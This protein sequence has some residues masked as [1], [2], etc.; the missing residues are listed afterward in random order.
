MPLSNEQ[1]QQFSDN[2]RT[3]KIICGALMGG[4]VMFALVLCTIIDIPNLNMD[5]PLLVVMAAAFGMVM[6]MMSF[7]MFKVL[8]GSTEAKSNDVQSHFGILQTA[9]IVRYALIEGACFLNLIVT[10]MHNSLISLFVAM[11]GL[12]VMLIAFPRTVVVEELLEDRMRG[13]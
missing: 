4:V 9:W 12:L 5:L 2:L 7:V 11:L 3:L 8:S 1:L 6:Y 10:M 13:N